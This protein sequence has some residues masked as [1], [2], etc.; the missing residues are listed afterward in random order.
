MSPFFSF[1]RNVFITSASF[2]ENETFIA[3]C[4]ID[5]DVDAGTARLLLHIKASIKTDKNT[6]K[7]PIVNQVI[8]CPVDLNA[9][10][11]LTY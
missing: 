4:R 5:C 2:H 10:D 6:V 8:E 9:I 7:W 3:Q 1:S 11:V